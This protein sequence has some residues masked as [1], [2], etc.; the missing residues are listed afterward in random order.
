[1]AYFGDYQ[2]TVKTCIIFLFQ[3]FPRD[4]HHV[5][6]LNQRGDKGFAFQPIQVGSATLLLP[7]F[8][9]LQS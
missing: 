8:G 4:T 3:I 2:K 7:A 5:S 6:H 1:M 9:C